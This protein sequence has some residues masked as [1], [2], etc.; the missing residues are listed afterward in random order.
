ELQG[1]PVVKHESVPAPPHG[2]GVKFGKNNEFQ[3]ELRRRVDE[4][5]ERTGR[6]RRDVPL[7]YLK[8]AIFLA[9]FAGLYYLL[10]F[11]AHT[12]WQGVPLAVLLGLTTAGIGFNI[13]HDGGHQA[14]SEHAW[15]NKMMALT[16]DLIGGSSYLWHYKH[17]V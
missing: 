5:F 3:A 13:Q 6:P 8:T 14:Y 1:N 16:L 12:W 7:M 9:A 10:V 15:V 11:V 17:G 4:Y 2:T